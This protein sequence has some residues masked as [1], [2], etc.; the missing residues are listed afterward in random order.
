MYRELVAKLSQGNEYV[1][2]Q[3]PCSEER[4]DEAERAVGYPFPE[5][6]RALLREMDGDRWLLLSAEDIIEDVRLNRECYAGE[7]SPEEYEDK[8]D[9]FIFFGGNGC[10]DYYCYRVGPDGAPEEDCLYIWEHEDLGGENWRPVAKSM[11]ELI[12]R[13]YNDEI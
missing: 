3:P 13:Y 6:L 8:V 11:E 12:T 5:E 9:R 1:K 2:I 7:F 4:I 10:G